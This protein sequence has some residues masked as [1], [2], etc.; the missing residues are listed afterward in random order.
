[1]KELNY[2]SIAE[3]AMAKIRKGAFLTV[4]SADGPEYDDYWL[5]HFRVHL[6]KADHDGSGARFPLH[7]WSYRKSS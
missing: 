4:K 3:E 7:L 2:M 5:G 1:M 6:A